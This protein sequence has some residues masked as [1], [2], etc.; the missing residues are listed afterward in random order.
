MR[1]LAARSSSSRSST[2]RPAVPRH[3][4]HGKL[5]ST[6]QRAMSSHGVVDAVLLGRMNQHE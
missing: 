3:D 6:V 1:S 2:S 4:G 5:G